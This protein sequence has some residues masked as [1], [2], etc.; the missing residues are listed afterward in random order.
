MGYKDWNEMLVKLGT[1]ILVAYVDRS[2]KPL[3][4][5]SPLGTALDFSLRDL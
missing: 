2:A 3:E 5:H 1:E 4:Q